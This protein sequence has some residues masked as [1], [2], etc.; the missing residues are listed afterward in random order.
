MDIWEG[1]ADSS[2]VLVY[3]IDFLREMIIYIGVKLKK[4]PYT[5]NFPEIL[6]DFDQFHIIY[7]CSQI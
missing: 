6:D 5:E 3:S 2:R 1:L 7:Y 4:E